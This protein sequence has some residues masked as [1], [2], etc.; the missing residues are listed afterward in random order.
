MDNSAHIDDSPPPLIQDPTSAQTRVPKI[1]AKSD[2]KTR[3]DF[4]KVLAAVGLILIVTIIISAGIWYFVG[5][6]GT[7]TTTDT[8]PTI[9]VSSDSASLAT[10]S[11]T[12]SAE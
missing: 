4:H 3:F 10:K 8:G 5:N 7:E 2:D 1:L 11:A 6:V 12:P 9:K